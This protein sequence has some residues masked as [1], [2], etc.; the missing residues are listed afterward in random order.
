MYSFA[1]CLLHDGELIVSPL[2]GGKL[3]RDPLISEI[4]TSEALYKC[5]LDQFV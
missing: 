5:G 1:Q 3:W 2:S 4:A